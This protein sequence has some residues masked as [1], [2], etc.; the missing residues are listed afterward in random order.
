MSGPDSAATPVNDGRCFGCGP[1]SDIGLKM[2]F[3]ID[4]ADRSVES[5]IAVGP[6]FVGWR[7]IVHGG[8]VSLI[9]DE[10]MGYAATAQGILGMTGELKVRFRKSV[11]VN[12][13]LV[14]RGHV[15]WQRRGVLGVIA[16][17]A[18][19]DGTLLASGE[20]TFVKHG[21]VEPATFGESRF[22]APA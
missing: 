3:E 6:A 22:R 20:G 21:D 7:G 13:P 19:E 16:S 2:R 11:L 14:V 9:L 8:I 4:P 1:L 18:T 17:I 15:A 12:V 10:A 5:R